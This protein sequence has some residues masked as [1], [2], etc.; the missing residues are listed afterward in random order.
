MMLL[1]VGRIVSEES[2]VAPNFGGD[3]EADHFGEQIK[4]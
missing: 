2:A 3:L 4:V 1:S